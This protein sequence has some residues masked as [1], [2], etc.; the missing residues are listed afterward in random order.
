MERERKNSIK[1]Y[2]KRKTEDTSFEEQDTLEK[3]KKGKKMASRDSKIEEQIEEL[4]SLV[5]NVAKELQEIRMENAEW[6]KE[7]KELREEVQQTSQRWKKK[8][9]KLES[10]IGELE[11]KWERKERQEKKN[12]LVIK[13]LK[14]NEDK[15]KPEVEEFVKKEIGVEVRFSKV[16]VVGKERKI[17]IATTNTWEEKQCILEKKSRLRSRQGT[18]KIFID[19]D[20]TEQDLRIQ[21]YISDWAKEHREEGRSVKMGYRKM[22]VDGKMWYWDNKSKKLTDTKN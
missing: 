4:T 20:K 5:K 2:Y 19:N 13:G 14:V 1:S 6:K 9:E 22:Q 15:V 7:M 18:R 12:N 3:N 17:I 21:A 8:V 10:K 16:R 11:E